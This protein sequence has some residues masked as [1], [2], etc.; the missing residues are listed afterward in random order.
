MAAACHYNHNVLGLCI[1][2]TYTTLPGSM[3]QCSQVLGT[4]TTLTT[5][6]P[7]RILVPPTQARPSASHLWHLCRRQLRA[8]ARH[9]QVHGVAL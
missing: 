3:M 7:C 2:K 8:Y 5:L 6:S 4:A 9:A 1:A